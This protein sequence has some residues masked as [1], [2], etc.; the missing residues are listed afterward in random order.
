MVDKILNS[1]SSHPS[2]KSTLEK[3]RELLG[4]PEMDNQQPSLNYKPLKEDNDYLICDDGRVFSEKTNRFISGKID[5]V[6][7]RVYSLAIWN[8]LTSKKGK[9]VY[10]HRLV[11]EYFLDN[12][13]NKP[14]VHHKD[15][16]RLNNHV[17]NLEWVSAKENN[18][19]LLKKNPNCRKGIKAHYKLEDLDGEEWK[20]VIENPMYSVSNYGRVINNRNNRL[21]K[22]DTTNKY[23]RVS[24]N[25][26]KHYF[27]HRLVYCTFHNDYD[28]K[29]YV[30]DHI[31]CNPSNNRLDNLQKITVVENNLRR[32]NDHPTAGVGAS[33]LKCD[34]PS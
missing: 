12:P 24:F 9:M 33:A 34:N 8:P 14:Y 29:G 3:N 5:N 10:A 18:Q 22:L 6:G 23:I 16:D 26:K 11:A 19:E 7:Y 17:S 4:N 27:I 1:S 15:E 31:D 13:E 21:L 2:A 20:V 30:I 28:L 25:D 32:F